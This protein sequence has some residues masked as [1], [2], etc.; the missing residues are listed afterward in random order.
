VAVDPIQAR[1]AAEAVSAPQTRM[2]FDMAAE[3]F[4]SGLEGG[5]KNSKHRQ[6]WRNTLSTYASPVVGEKDVAA[7]GT[8]DVLT[9]LKPIWLTKRETAS[10]VRGRIENV[11]D[12][13]EVNHFRSGK[14]PATWRNH[15][16]YLLPAQKKRRNVRHHPAM[17]WREVP[18]F[19]IELRGNDC[20]SARALEFTILTA[21]RT[22]ETLNAP[23]PNSMLRGANGIFRGRA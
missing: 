13:A 10:R 18:A 3:R 12:W 19:M 17:P 16:R 7:I 23:G 21:V 6:Q 4:I 8:E 2:T 15:L 22:S 11:L 9:I 5:W 1:K 14:N 20:I